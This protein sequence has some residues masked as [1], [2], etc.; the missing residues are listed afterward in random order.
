MKH[1]VSVIFG[2][3]LFVALASAPAPGADP[4]RGE[5]VYRKY[6]AFCHGPDGAGLGPAYEYTNPPPRDFT[7]GTYKWRSTPAEAFSPADE[8]FLVT[9]G[10]HDTESVPGWNG[11]GGA[12]MPGWSDVLSKK[13]TLDV[14]A[15]LRGLGYLES[16]E[17]EPVSTDGRPSQA[18]LDRGGEI[19][20]ELCSECHGEKGRGDGRKR[21]RDDWGARTW[22]RNL[23]KGWTYRMTPS[24]EEVYRRV[25]IGIP[26]TQMPSF[27]VR[28]SRKYLTEEER[29]AVA[30]YTASLVDP[31]KEPTGET[32]ITAVRAGRLPSAPG[33]PAWQAA[34]PVGFF[35][36]PQLMEP[37]R[38]YKP[39]LDSVTVRAVY[40]DS[41][42]ALL[43]EWDDR[44]ESVPGDERAEDVAGGEVLRDMA[45][46][47]FPREASGTGRKPYLGMGDGKRPVD[48]WLW[49]GPAG[50]GKDGEAEAVTA[51]GSGS[52]T[53]KGAEGL[54][55]TGEYSDGTWRVVFRR[56]FSEAGRG[57]FREGEFIPVAFAAWDGSNGEEGSRHTMT[58][59][60]N[61][62]LA[63][64][65]GPGVWAWP[66]AAGAAV[67]AA[68]F[69]LF[70]AVR[71]E[72]RG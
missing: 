65:D 31:A 67:A 25:T 71:R 18:D 53:R 69:F 5:E 40:N 2:A 28:E 64:D 70:I 33:D 21:L 11:L 60:Y 58:P 1:L 3:A 19:F 66:L 42:V 49:K 16:P 26:G 43:L 55:A 45:A 59:W 72:G 10:G 51:R 22:P 61:L 20:E 9:I 63:E 13:E 56:D 47:Q 23:T 39:T 44:T 41:G 46:V 38:L 37:E 68:E 24:V 7:F 29:W 57:I 6:C 32:V 34:A 52:I 8:D 48:I 35:L 36:A 12:S 4:G 17:Y 14:A 30:G 54:E 27:A 50:P 15:Y 62:R